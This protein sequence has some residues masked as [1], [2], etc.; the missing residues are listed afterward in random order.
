MCVIVVKEKEAEAVASRNFINNMRDP[1]F[2]VGFV[3][4][5][6]GVSQAPCFC[7]RHQ[8]RQTCSHAV[9]APDCKDYVL[10]SDSPEKVA[11]RLLYN[12]NNVRRQARHQKVAA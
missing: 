10:Y 1:A 3:L 5:E 2:V 9:G 7:C 12:I 6:T 11:R 8:I 4:V